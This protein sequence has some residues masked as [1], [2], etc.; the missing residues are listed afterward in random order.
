MKRALEHFSGCKNNL[1]AAAE[2]K[3]LCF[4]DNVALLMDFRDGHV[5]LGTFR[6]AT[7]EELEHTPTASRVPFIH[8]WYEDASGAAMPATLWS[9]QHGFR[10]MNAEAYYEKNGAQDIR[11]LSHLDVLTAFAG[12]GLSSHLKHGTPLRSSLTVG[13]ILLIAAKYPFTTSPEGTALPAPEPV[14]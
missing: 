13:E 12:M 6:A 7:A 1:M 3:G 8:C 11:R 10:R 4:H 2:G 14:E 5:C 9:P